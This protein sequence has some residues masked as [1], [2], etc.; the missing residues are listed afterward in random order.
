LSPVV[1]HTVGGDET[2]VEEGLRRLCEVRRI[3]QDRG[4]EELPDGT[5]A[6][7]YRFSHGLYQEVLYQDLV[8]SR[9]TAL[10][11]E[12]A[13]RLRHHWGAEAP[14]LA[15][16]IARHCE[17]GRDHEQAV[18]YR[19]HAGDNEAQ[20][21][22]YD[23]A[24]GHYEWASRSIEK[25]PL[26]ERLER[27]VALHH[28]RGVLRHAQARFD[29]AIGDFEAM[30]AG[31][32]ET[33]SAEDEHVA[34]GGLCDALFFA[35]RV[36]EMALRAQEMLEIATRSGRAS[37]LVDARSRMGQVLVCEGHFGEAIPALDGVIEAAR[38]SGPPVALRIGLNLRGLVHY[39]QTEY[40]Q[41]ETLMSEAVAV[42]SDAGDAFNVLLA[43]MFV[44]L[45]RVK[46]GRVSEGLQ[47]FLEGISL[48]RRNRDRFW[49]PHLVSYMGWAHR[50]VLA[51]ERAREFDTEA[52]RLVQEASLPQGP[53]TEVLLYLA[54]DEV[55]LGNV[56]RASELLAELEAKVAERV[57]F[58][59]MDELRL[60]AVSAEH[61]RACGELDRAAEHASRL[62]GLARRLG[63]RDYLCG[64][65]RV[66]AEAALAQGRDLDS[67]AQHLTEALDGFRDHPALLE[68][69]RSARVLGRLHL[70]L[71][72][73]AAA[74][75]AFAEAAAAVR[76]IA[77]GV[78]DEAL[79]EGFLNA[80]PVREVLEAAPE[81]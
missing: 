24:G 67:A 72:D 1:A 53:E 2:E 76:T 46:L 40:G 32:R 5:I 25:L 81:A 48:A 68:V 10:H 31:A 56:D 42:A 78:A 60:G 18:V 79:R 47:E 58:R 49:L 17:L 51:H 50:E 14:R 66:R 15:A 71:G 43:R 33:G 21:Y 77:A 8:P 23:E 39:W 57:W 73:E 61:W 6:T 11:R 64:A 9:R 62:I 29:E 74:G 38:R 70:R 30:L 13:E 20:R 63:T 41:A 55:R 75:R 59:W 36:D 52:L 4:E 44:G 65:E 37:D 12:V 19:L 54:E 28:K 45:S 34:L 80:E 3:I 69:W 22:H 27:V 7:R 35:R 26:E 16:E